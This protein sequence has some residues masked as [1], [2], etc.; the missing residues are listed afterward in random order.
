MATHDIPREEWH[1]YLEEFSR[2]HGGA[3]VTIETVSAGDDPRIEAEA[4]PLVGI[5][6]ETKGDEIGTILLL[7]GAEPDDHVTHAIEAPKHVYH[8]SGAGMISDEVNAGE[9][10]EITAASHPA[11]TQ[12]QFRPRP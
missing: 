10:L 9:I 4:L 6:Y 8:K 12:L 2:T 7:L 5:S 3:L 11:I 1:A